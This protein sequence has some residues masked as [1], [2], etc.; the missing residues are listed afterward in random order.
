MEVNNNIVNLNEL[1]KDYDRGLVS[2][3]I[4]AGFS[5]NVSSL[6]LDWNSL[7]EDLIDD[8][9]KLEINQYI[10]NYSYCTVG[11]YLEVEKKKRKEEFIGNLLNKYGYL[12]IVSKYIGQKGY[13]EV[14]EDYIEERT[15]YVKRNDNGTISLYIKDKKKSDI[16]ESDFSAHKQLL[17]CDKFKNIYTTNYDNLLEFTSDYFLESPI[18]MVKSS[19]SLSNGFQNR[20]IIKIHGSL[21]IEDNDEFEFDGD[22]H[23]RYIIAQ[24]DYETYIEK[25]EAF[26]HL[27]RISMLQGK[28]CLLGF[29]GNNPNYMGWVKWISDILGKGKDK[30]PKIYL[31]TFKD[32]EGS[33]KKLYY[34]NHYIREINLMD[35][36]VLTLLRYNQSEIS[37]SAPNSYKEIL[38]SFL[39][40]LCE[41]GNEKSAETGGKENNTA[42]DKSK[43]SIEYETA[44]VELTNSE[45]TTSFVYKELWYTAST[46][47]YNQE[48]LSD[49]IKRIKNTK[50]NYQFCKIVDNQEYFIETA[51]RR[52]GNLTED[53]AY[54][55]ALAVKETGQLPCFYSSL[56]QDKPILDSIP[57][58]QELV[59]RSET[60]T[61]SEEV[62]HDVISSDY[63]T[64]ENIQ[65]KLFHL[66]FKTAQ[67]LLE[68]WD[69]KGYWLQ[70]KAMRLAAFNGSEEA[71]NLI[72]S[73]I[74]T[75]DNIQ[76]KMYA[77][78]L[79]NYIS[80]HYP[81][82]YNLDYFLRNNIYG[83]GEIIS[84]I[85]EKLNSKEDK[86]KQRGWIGSTHRFGRDN[87][88]YGQSLR[89]LQ[90][91]FDT[92]LYLN[93]GITYFVDI[94]DW[95]KICKNL[96]KYFPYP[97]FFYSIQYNDKDVLER[98]GQ[99][100]AFNPDLLEENQELLLSSLK[101]Y[102]SP[103]T[104]EIFLSGILRIT[105]PLYLCVDESIWFENFKANIFDS[106]I[107]HIT[108]YS[109][110]EA[111]V[112][113]V[114]SA[115][116]CLKNK[117]HI[118]IILETLLQ[119]AKDNM[120]IAQSII[121]SHMN[122]KYLK[123]DLN[124]V[125]SNFLK[126]LIGT[127]PQNDIAQIIYILNRN[128]CFPEELLNLFMSKLKEVGFDDI[129][130]KIESLFYICILAKGDEEI[131]KKVKQKILEKDIWHCGVLAEGNGWSTPNYIRLQAF[132]DI[133]EWDDQEFSIISNNLRKN[134]SKYNTL[135]EKFRN[136]SFM[137]N[138]QITY[139]SDVL[140]Y[141]NTL[142]KERRKSLEDVIVLAKS[143]LS[144]RV[145]YDSFIEA[146]LSEQ[147]A[148]VS[149]GIDNVV[150]GIRSS[151][152]KK[153]HNEINFIVDR[154]II[155]AQLSLSKNLSIIKWLIRNYEQEF[156]KMEIESKL[157]ILLS[158]YKKRWQEMD[159]FR[160]DHSFEDLY[161][162]A[163]Y[164]KK[165]GRDN[166]SI[167]YWL[168]DS[169]VRI[170]L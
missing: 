86:P 135:P 124:D 139:L 123:G 27:M 33:G 165:E 35:N 72:S 144:S 1:K 77:C 37:L 163:N 104:P 129:P 52:K 154:A 156:K 29:S 136:D 11:K 107:S 5:K 60:L 59:Q 74:E 149:S 89:F 105:T 58:W 113:N 94:K 42:E 117:N 82:P 48:D 146:M 169:F 115:V 16:I 61:G 119:H 101:A 161:Y 24:E 76:E 170:F 114:D 21:K 91:I 150:Q 137:R 122:L 141:I 46:K 128:H 50:Y 17:L 109:Y 41:T 32:E 164:L 96:F 142:S 2:A 132:N 151:G 99:D 15:P 71:F 133:T 56:L 147:S 57:L 168:T 97:C 159:E 167:Q 6:Y 39:K 14:I 13:R 83:Q 68:G 162:I 75:L 9:F 98:I 87:S 78:V 10:S 100:Y 81:R 102:G 80:L 70:A 127:Y 63:F 118:S 93:Y 108:E 90:F 85:V 43:S 103:Y 25:H 110:N 12:G 84:Y 112:E 38:E 111:I 69:A 67:Q 125:C 8:L 51:L 19:W 54:L 36:E 155:G 88:R 160:P 4:G 22:K 138:V 18:P 106:M 131:T 62:L 64:Y 26:S 92:G 145:S 34:K 152:L 23:L 49:I 3:L 130:S 121:C 66:D 30:G 44:K 53:E 47:F 45:K 95:Y 120:E 157:L 7:L 28:F 40:F 143:L 148:D 134:I 65:R 153:Y 79:A 158:V 73:Y 55:F 126:E 140:Q 166:D 116:A 20:S 31:V